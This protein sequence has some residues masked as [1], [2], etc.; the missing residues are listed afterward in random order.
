MGFIHRNKVHGTFI[1]NTIES[2]FHDGDGWWFLLHF[3]LFWLNLWIH[4]TSLF[5][6]LSTFSNRFP[7]D[8]ATKPST[9]IIKQLSAPCIIYI[10]SCVILW[11]FLQIL[12]W[13]RIPSR[14]RCAFVIQM[15]SGVMRKVLRLINATVSIDWVDMVHGCGSRIW[16]WFQR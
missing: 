5:N 7:K 15:E 13:C 1:L 14:W 8:S 4:C 12:C 16:L 6:D 2:R 11:W 3:V 10:S 9:H